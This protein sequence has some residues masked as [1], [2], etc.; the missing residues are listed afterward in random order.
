[1][2]ILSHKIVKTRDQHK[3]FACCKIFEKGT[4]MIRQ[5]NVY[6]GIQAIYTCLTCDEL[7]TKYKDHFWDYMCDWFPEQCVLD[8]LQEGGT[9]EQLLERLNQI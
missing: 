3:C 4:Q 2:N 9:P 7:M 8:A 1:M 6:D 5:V